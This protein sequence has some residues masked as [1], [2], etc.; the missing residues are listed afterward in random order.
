[1]TTAPPDPLALQATLVDFALAELVRQH[2]TSFQPLWSAESWAKLLI[3]L[4]LNCG[5]SGDEAGLK[6]FAAALGPV[7]TGRMRRVFF[8]R[9]LDD[10]DLQLMA[11]PAEQQLLVLPQGPAD[12]VLQ[13]D[14]IAQAL[15]RVGLEQRV[16]ADRSRWQRL[17]ALVAIPWRQGEPCS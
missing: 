17:E 2:R 3:W 8:E 15:E 13:P 14:A 16:V 12:L 11:D 10:L 7:Q 9:E 5:C 4:A 6:T 1:M